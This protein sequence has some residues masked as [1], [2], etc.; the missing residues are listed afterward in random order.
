MPTMIL[1]EDEVFE[2]NSLVN[3]IDWKLVGVQIIGEASNGSQGF[4]LVE[5]LR[6]DIVLTDV[7][8]PVMNGIELSR[9]IRRHAPETK[10]IFLS[11]YDDFEY[12]K[13]AIDLNIQAYVMKP[14]NE[15]ELLRIVKKAADEITEKALEQRMYSEIKKSYSINVSLAHEAL[16]SRMLMGMRTDGENA[17]NLRLEW[18]CEPSPGKLCLLLSLYDKNFTKSIDKSIASL[19]KNCARLCAQSISVCMTPG[20]LI[21]FFC[22]RGEPDII[23]KMEGLLQ[24][25]FKE[26]NIKPVKIKMVCGEGSRRSPYELYT[27]LLRRSV[28]PYP[29]HGPADE[30]KKNKQQIADEVEEIIL[31]QYQSQLTLESIAKQMHFTPNYLGTVF[32]SVKKISVN[33]FLMKTRLEKAEEFL[34]GST[35]M[36]NEIADQC[37]FG[38]LTYFHTIFK[39]ETGLTPSDFRHG[40]SEGQVNAFT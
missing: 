13:Q 40:M 34:R 2:R 37:G 23:K 18:L 1:V 14:V 4:S 15:V 32:K 28:R 17:R 24:K 39:K 31:A 38:S 7:K 29:G 35:L 33:R 3:C 21:T 9:K 16:I 26:R 11:S 25:F 30:K 12:A 22:V 6:P 5:K 19:N 36:I 8:M 10:I 27:E 20:I